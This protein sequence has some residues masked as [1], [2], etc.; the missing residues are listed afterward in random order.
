MRT[1]HILGG[2]VVVALIGGF[3]L[4]RDGRVFP[5]VGV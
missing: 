4:A 5:L 2:L 3:R 1:K